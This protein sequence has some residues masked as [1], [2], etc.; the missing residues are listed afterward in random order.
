MKVNRLPTLMLAIALQIL[1]ICRMACV[2]ETGPR[3][4][5]AILMKWMAGAGVLLGGLDAMSGASAAI[6]GVY[7]TNPLGLPSFTATGAVT[8]AF[9]YQI[10]VTSPGPNPSSAFYRAVPLPAGLILN[11]NLGGNGMITGTPTV[12]GTNFPVTLTAGNALYPGTNLTTNITIIIWAPPN[13]T[14]PPTNQAAPVGGNASFTVTATGS[15]PFTYKWQFAGT[16]I[17]KAT[18]TTLLL[19]S[20]LATDF[21]TY[22]V[23]VSGPGGSSSNSAT[24]SVSSGVIAPT[25]TTQPQSLTVTNGNDALFTVVASGTTP[26]YQWRF[27]GTNLPGATA[28]SLSIPSAQPVNSGD[29]VVDVW[30]SAG[31]NTSNPAHLTVL[32]PPGITTQPQ[33]L[34]VTNGNSALFSVVASGTTPSYQWTFFGTNLPGATSSSL[35]ILKA[36]PANSGDYTVVVSN[37]AGTTNSNPAHLTVL[38]QLVPPILTNVLWVVDHIEFDVAGPSQISNVVW[39][40]TNVSLSNWAAIQTNYSAAGT[41]HCSCTNRASGIG[42][43]RVSLSP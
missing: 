3:A 24:L 28:A 34:T 19:T 25:I 2:S 37:G 38:V 30:N 12:A 8:H 40:S 35:S 11:T 43:Y 26:N 21:G 1:P 29:Y 32:V 7:N 16:N 13:I 5:F 17:A 36:Q 31:T 33:S 42:F 27:F 6:G 14:G 18:N 9:A 23:V 22:T 41:V 10:W 20:L 4:G 39:Y 15:G